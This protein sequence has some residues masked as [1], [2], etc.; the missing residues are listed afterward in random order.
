M[1]Y[2]YSVKKLSIMENEIKNK[3]ILQSTLKSMTYNQD[4]N[5]KKC[6][7]WKA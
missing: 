5:F 7:I 3:K 6:P 4:V 2:S 1:E